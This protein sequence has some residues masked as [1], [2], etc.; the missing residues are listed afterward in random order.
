MWDRALYDIFNPE[1]K[2]KNLRYKKKILAITTIY[3]YIYSND[4]NIT[5]QLNLSERKDKVVR[6]GKTHKM[7]KKGR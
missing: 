7:T 4:K 1:K 3:I 5:I 6:E 2:I